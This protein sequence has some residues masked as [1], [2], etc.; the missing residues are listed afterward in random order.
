MPTPTFAAEQKGK[1][2]LNPEVV[3]R[4]W[5]VGVLVLV[6][7][8][9]RNELARFKVKFAPDM[10]PDFARQDVTCFVL[11]WI[12]N[13]VFYHECLRRALA[14]VVASSSS[15]GEP[16]PS[17]PLLP[18]L[19][20]QRR[21]PGVNALQGRML[22]ID[23][24]DLSRRRGFSLDAEQTNVCFAL[25][26]QAG[27][28]L[29]FINALAGVGK[30]ALLKLHFVRRHFELQGERSSRRRQGV[31]GPPSIPGASRG[32]GARHH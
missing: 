13:K 3:E 5:Q 1:P 2:A 14:S 11:D 27:V 4:I 19:V 17:A 21:L 8:A 10:P 29:F 23:F 25:N 20:P 18:I 32:L 6:A 24:D 7:S 22:D 12:G 9:P 28:P 30:T 26:N 16:Q 15:V 31:A